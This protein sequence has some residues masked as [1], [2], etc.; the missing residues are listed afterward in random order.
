LSNCESLKLIKDVYYKCPNIEDHRCYT[1][2]K[3]DDCAI[4]MALLYVL[5]GDEVYMI[6]DPR[7][8]ERVLGLTDDV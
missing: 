7:I 1:W 2:W 6:E 4:L 3:H 8:W 5:T